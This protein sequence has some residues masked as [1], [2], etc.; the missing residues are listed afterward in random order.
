ML[1]LMALAP[2]FSRTTTSPAVET[3]VGLVG[4]LQRE[5]VDVDND[6]VRPAWAMTPV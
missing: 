3:V 2:A 4:V 6:R 1:M 5:R